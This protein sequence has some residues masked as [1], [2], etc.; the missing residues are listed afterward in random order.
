MKI[1]VQVILGGRSRKHPQEMV[2]QPGQR[3]QPIRWCYQTSYLCGPLKLSHRVNSGRQCGMCV[4]QLPHPRC[5]LECINSS[6]P[7][8]RQLKTASRGDR[9]PGNSELPLGQLRSRLRAK[10]CSFWQSEDKLV[11]PEV[12]PIG[13]GSGRQR[14]LRHLSFFHHCILPGRAA[15]VPI[16]IQGLLV[17]FRLLLGSRELCANCL[18]LEKWSRHYGQQVQD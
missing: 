12:V 14:P 8:R 3:K 15:Y 16:S 18:Q 2:S 13:M 11:G 9:F 7:I 17:S 5:K 6:K 4:S 1:Q 10:E